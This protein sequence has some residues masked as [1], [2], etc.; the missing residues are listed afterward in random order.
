MVA[1]DMG[2]CA[3]VIRVSR[4]CLGKCL[5]SVLI[6]YQNINLLSLTN[7]MVIEDSMHFGD[8]LRIP[9]N[10][11]ADPEILIRGSV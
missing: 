7:C 8:L 6:T 11:G 3:A 4:K 10:A 5:E 1:Q 9:K 2:H